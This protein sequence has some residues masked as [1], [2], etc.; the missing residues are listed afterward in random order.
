MSL[1]FWKLHFWNQDASGP[2]IKMVYNMS[3]S[4]E[5]QLIG[6]V[7]WGVWMRNMKFQSWTYLLS[8]SHK[9]AQLWLWGK[10]V[11]HAQELIC[12]FPFPFWLH[13]K[14]SQWIILQNSVENVLILSSPM[15]Q[16]FHLRNDITFGPKCYQG[17]F[18]QHT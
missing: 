5:V 9:A 17:M 3:M 4:I 15:Q 7:S 10:V 11:W 18:Q 1:G 8:I 12:Q 16:I 13:H 14:N 6:P 2:G